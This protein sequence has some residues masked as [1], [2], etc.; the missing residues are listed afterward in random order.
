[1][2]TTPHVAFAVDNLDDAL[3]GQEVLIAPNAPSPGVRVA[4][5]VHNGAPVELLEFT[6]SVRQS[7]VSDNA[8]EPALA[9]DGAPVQA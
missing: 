5:I 3:R 6:G 8:D 2:K 7:T 9:P 4:F 1:V